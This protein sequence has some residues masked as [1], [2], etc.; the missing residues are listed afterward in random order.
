MNTPQLHGNGLAL[1]ETRT[2]IPPLANE[3]PL[4]VDL[5]GTLIK[6]DLIWESLVSFVKYHSNR[7]L[8]LP[9]WLLRGK[10]FFKSRLARLVAIAPITLPYDLVLLEHLKAQR[11][12]GRRLTLA[13]GSHKRYAKQI[14]DHLGIFD[15]VLGS[16]SK[17]NLVGRNKA[18]VLNQKYGKGCFDYIGNSKVDTEVWLNSKTAWSV[19]KRPFTL[20]DSRKT[21]WTGSLRVGWGVALLVALRP[22]QWLKNS[23][24]FLPVLAAHNTSIPVLLN[25]II[26]LVVFSLCAS[27]AY[28]LND[29]LDASHDRVHATKKFRPIAAG[30]LP[31]PLAIGA[32]IALVGASLTAAALIDLGLLAVLALYFVTTVLYST[33]L[34]RLAIVDVVSLA[35]LYSFRLL[36]GAA[37]TDV[38]PSFWLLTFSFFIFLS[39]AMLKR[40]SELFNMRRL[41]DEKAN[42]RGYRVVDQEAIGNMGIAAAFTAVLVFLLYFNSPN[43]LVMYSSPNILLA[44]T[45]ALVFWLCRLWLLGFRGEV[46]EDPVLFVSTDRTSLVTMFICLS[47]LIL[48]S[49]IPSTV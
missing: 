26:A 1:V 18:A 44:M 12:Q 46:D 45:P 40:Y 16:T 34:K 2:S 27:S 13:T 48:A 20:R 39:L 31:V 49:I 21:K 23:I 28:L 30:D 36:G 11:A 41:G 14:A 35:I 17:L 42:G 7:L 9:L 33:Y 47:L 29:S 10:A 15:T 43:V 8:E 37:A 19:T 24:V 5:D 4:V 3:P 22:R 6:S 38:V 32:S 25:A